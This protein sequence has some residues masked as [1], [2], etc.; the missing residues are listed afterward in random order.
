MSDTNTRLLEIVSQVLLLDVD[1]IT[2]TLK[3]KEYEP[4][5]SMAHLMLIS[6]VENQ[7][8]IFFEDE[9]IVEIWTVADLKEALTKKLS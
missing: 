4:W 7:F 6:E 5:D 1:Q 9:E 3:R 2:D 8:E